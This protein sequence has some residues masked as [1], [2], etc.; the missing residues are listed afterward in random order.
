MLFRGN[1]KLLMTT[2]ISERA[3]A[4]VNAALN[5]PNMGYILPLKVEFHPVCYEAA[6]VM[7]H[8]CDQTC[9]FLK[10]KKGLNK[11]EMSE[12]IKLRLAYNCCIFSLL[13]CLV[14]MKYESVHSTK[15]LDHRCI[16]S[17]I[18]ACTWGK[19][20]V[21]KLMWSSYT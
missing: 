14:S 21:V 4:N 11:V 5:I 13:C 17:Q 8:H 19:C 20:V 12:Q 3:F 7:S 1:S 9:F 18:K 10:S 15:S 2:P 16:V 6:C